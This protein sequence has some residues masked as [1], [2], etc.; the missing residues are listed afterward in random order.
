MH[1]PY[2]E[3]FNGAFY[4]GPIACYLCMFCSFPFRLLFMV[5]VLHLEYVRMTGHL[6][7]NLE[8]IMTDAHRVCMPIQV[9]VSSQYCRKN[10]QTERI[11]TSIIYRLFRLFLTIIWLFLQY[12]VRYKENAFVS[13]T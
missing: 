4:W 9:V 7:D 13:N 6:M 2:Y 11:L 1:A 10:T 3:M 5:I 12:E 8:M